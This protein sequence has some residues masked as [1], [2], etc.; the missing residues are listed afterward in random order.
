V[1][2]PEFWS[3]Q[4]VLLTGHTGFKGAWL[5]LWL[6][7]L[8]AEV[9]GLALPPD[10]TTG[11]FASIQPGLSS[12]T[13]ADLRDPVPVTTAFIETAPTVVMHLAAQAVVSRGYEQPAETMDTNVMGTVHVLEAARAAGTVRALLVVTTDKVYADASSRPAREDDSLG[14]SDPYSSSKACAE[15]VVRAWRE[16]FFRSAGIVIATARAG[17]V[18]G[19]GDESPD[20]LVPDIL[21]AF[22]AGAAPTLRNPDS[23][24]PW[25]HV[26]DPLHGYL[27]MVQRMG[28]GGEGPQCPPSLNFGPDEPPWTVLEVASYLQEKLGARGILTADGDGMNEASALLLDAGLARDSIGWTP[29]LDTRSALEWTAEWAMARRAGAPL[30][31]LAIEQIDRFLNMVSA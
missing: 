24:R 2:D 7:R 4:R 8:G 14:Y 20:R 29:V 30:R 18:I 13:F 16:S 25:Q 10:T 9:H 15:L 23:V 27:L 28:V 3:S 26:L 12:S 21:R 11:A 6:E 1:I 17:N 19:G 22:D 5:A 31:D